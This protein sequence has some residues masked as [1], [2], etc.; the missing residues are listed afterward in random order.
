V[1]ELMTIPIARRYAGP[2]PLLPSRRREVAW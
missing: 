1:L 2:P